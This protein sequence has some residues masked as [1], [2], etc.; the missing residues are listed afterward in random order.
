MRGGHSAASFLCKPSK[1]VTRRLLWVRPSSYPTRHSSLAAGRDGDKRVGGGSTFVN[2][3]RIVRPG[4]WYDGR[5]P[6]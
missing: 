4:K 5:M 3:C 1:Q 6:L 2:I